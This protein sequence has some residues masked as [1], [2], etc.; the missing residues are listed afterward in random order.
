VDKLEEV[1]LLVS[2]ANLSRGGLRW[3]LIAIIF[4]Y[5]TVA[6]IVETLAVLW[7]CV[8]DAF[9]TLRTPGLNHRPNRLGGVGASGV[10]GPAPLCASCDGSLV[11][12]HTRYSDDYVTV[13]VDLS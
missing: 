10:D 9:V 13:L 8:K 2:P 11:W 6:R 4:Q 3:A 12:R 5:P 7:N 1:P